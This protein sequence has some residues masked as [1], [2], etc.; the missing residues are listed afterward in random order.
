MDL[1]TLWQRFGRAARGP[2]TEA[3]AVLIVE[4]KYFDEEKEKA[5][6]RA[7]KRKDDEAKKAAAKEQ[8]KRKRGED[9]EAAD[10]PTNRARTVTV[11]VPTAVSANQES[12]SGAASTSATGLSKYEELRVA[13]KVWKA[14]LCAR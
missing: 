3:I 7:D 12:S 10:R 6:K 14:A 4:P 2:G 1:D 9:E 11:D 5:A 8:S 13:Y